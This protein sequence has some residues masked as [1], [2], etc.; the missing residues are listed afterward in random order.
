MID[1]SDNVCHV[2]I[3]NN[4]VFLLC[5]PFVFLEMANG[6]ILTRKRVFLYVHFSYIHDMHEFNLMDIYVLIFLD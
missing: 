2:D 3:N 6:D 4:F 1:L 5:L